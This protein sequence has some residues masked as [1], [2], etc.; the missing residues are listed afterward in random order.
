V[1]GHGL[2]RDV[3]ISIIAAAAFGLPAYMLR[4]PLLLAYLAAG[5]VLGPHLGASV[6]KSHA[7]IATL[8]EIGLVLLMFILGLEIDLRKLMQAGKA[9]LVNGVTQFVGCAALAAVV[10]GLSGMGAGGGYDLVYIAVA[11]SLS[12]TLVVIKILSDRFELDTLTARITLGVLVIQDLWAIG[13]LALQPNLAD[14][15]PLAVLVSVGKAAL[16]ASA[17]WAPARYLLPWVFRQ[18]SKQPELMLVVAMAWCFGICGIADMLSLSLEMGALVA[19][20]TIASFPYHVDIASKI[21]SLRDFFITLFFVALGLQIPAPTGEVLVLAAAI[22]AFVLVSRVLVVFPVLHLLKYG[23]RASLIPALNL[24]QLSEFSLVLAGLGL[25]YGHIKPQLM[26]AFVIAMVVTA[27]LSSFIIPHAN[28]I[29]VAV[30]PWLERIG[31]KDGFGHPAVDN[32]DG[33]HPDVLLLGFFRTASS[34]LQVVAERHSTAWLERLLVVDFN[35]EAHRK[36]TQKGV[37]CKY[38]DLSHY[39]TLKNLEL[40][41]AKIIVCTIPDYFLKGTTNA[42]LLQAVRPLAPEAFIIV[43]AET[44]ASARE[45][46]QKGADYVFMPRMVSAKFLADIIDR[47]QAV[48]TM[49]LKQGS[50]EFIDA[51][52]E[53]IG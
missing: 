22:I 35:P 51:W 38:G 14:L 42:K 53:V 47:V 43:T 5:M 18:V 50:A 31:W 39:D 29:Y 9:V 48:D 46:Y 20:V 45:M 37:R 3:G 36:L 1:D 4:L 11:G 8:S 19:G 44:A 21:S 27:L 15:R 25:T 49:G 23:N 6:I 41:K 28:Q 10:F 17:A 52:Q 30:N 7:N 32:D 13:F 16:L 34:L 24:S 33:K 40:E 12:S 2:L 26:S